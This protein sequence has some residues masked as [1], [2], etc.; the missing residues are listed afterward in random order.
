MLYGSNVI[1]RALVGA[2]KS[3]LVLLL[4]ISGF[5]CGDS[6]SSVRSDAGP[7]D[8]GPVDAPT[9]LDSGPTCIPH[10]SPRGIVAYDTSARI[11]NVRGIHLVDW[12][13]FL[14]NPS[15]TITLQPPADIS[16]PATATITAD[17]PRL[18]FDLPSE[19]GASG[20]SKSLR[21]DSA[22][23]RVI[24]HLGIFPDRDGADE[25]HQLTMTLDGTDPR[26]ETVPIT[27]HD[28]DK[29]LPF[30]TSVTMDFTN[31]QTGFFDNAAA[32]TVV[33]QAIDDW[34]YFLDDMH[35]DS[36]PEFDESTFIWDPTGFLSG[37]YV[38]NVAAYTGFL[39]YAYGI[40]GTEL[41]SGGAGSYAGKPAASRGTALPLRRSGSIEIE[42]Q[43]NYN[44]LGWRID[45][46]P[47]NW[48]KDG[49][50]GDESNDLYSIVHHD[51]GHAYGFNTAYPQFAAAK[52]AGLSTPAL[53]AYTGAPIAIDGTDHFAGVV[54][55]ASGLGAFG[56][57]YNGQ[58]PARRWIMTRTDVLAL[59]AVGYKLRPL[60][61]ERWQDTVPDCP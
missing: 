20:P 10:M 44:T 16:F 4:G 25:H 35:L 49:N 33:Q 60:S 57:E 12:D 7:A 48:W 14:A 18:Y 46:D 13:G 41:R 43:G 47:D 55:P 6:A 50:L 34:C 5:G 29:N 56:N 36:V 37:H 39:L 19:V 53:L 32:R 61:F 15:E 9:P 3:S 58:M 11:L 42:T 22:E 21:F 23:T 30:L 31:D 59:E 40:H 28:Q 26:S 2:R 51:V 54:D 27:V 52:I 1:A 45:L 38:E 17:H 24:I 8:A